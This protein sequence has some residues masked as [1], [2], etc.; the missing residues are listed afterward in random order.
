MD[1]EIFVTPM[2][3]VKKNAYR[4]FYAKSTIHFFNI[5]PYVIGAYV[6]IFRTRKFLYPS[7]LVIT[8]SV[9]LISTTILLHW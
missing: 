4:L 3:V 5:I 1:R 9:F 6:S 8:S 2:G 7:V